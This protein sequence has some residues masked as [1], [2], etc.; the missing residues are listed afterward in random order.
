MPTPRP[1]TFQFWLA[2]PLLLLLAAAV[3]P[4]I[5][6]RRPPPLQDEEHVLL[7]SAATLSRWALHYNGLVAAVYWTRAVQYFGERHLAKRRH[8]PL[9]RPLLNLTLDL[10][11]DLTEAAQYGSYFLADAVPLGAGDPQGAVAL[12]QRAIARQPDNWRLYFNLGFVYALNLHDRQKAAEAFYRGSLRPNAHPALKVLAAAYLQ[13]GNEQRLAWALWNDLYASS[14]DPLTRANAHDH[15]EAILAQND[16]AH[17]QDVIRDYRHRTGHLPADWAALGLPAPPRDPEGRAYQLEPNGQ[18]ALDPA[19]TI[20][21][22]Q[23]PAP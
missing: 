19:T 3:Q 12:L 18:V 9:L 13:G 1:T 2:V 6:A 7:P 8:F 21:S 11:P 4:A 23:P 22:Y 15:I 17:W 5:E 10:D 16:V 14:P 20:A